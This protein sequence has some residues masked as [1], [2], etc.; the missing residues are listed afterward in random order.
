[1]FRITIWDQ[2][3]GS[4]TYQNLKNIADRVDLLLD[5]QAETIDGITYLSQRYDTDQPFEVQS[6][7]R[8]DYGLTLL[9]KF[10]TII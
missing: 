8:V 10:I 4:L 7:G 2:S 1:L 9:Y 6:D 5:Q 3:N